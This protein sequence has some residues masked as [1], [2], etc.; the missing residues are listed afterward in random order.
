[1]NPVNWIGVV[2]MVLLI[3]SL[4][5]LFLTNEEAF[6]GLTLF[7]AVIGIACLIIGGDIDSRMTMRNQEKALKTMG[8][9]HVKTKRADIAKVSLPGYPIGCKLTVEKEG[10]FWVVKNPEDFSRSIF[11]ANE[12]AKRP[13][14]Q[15]WCGQPQPK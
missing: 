6:Y 11:N 5:A 3:L 4:V 12:V 1:M 13:A 9:T 14:I 15:K 7:F 10:H 2:C 8:F